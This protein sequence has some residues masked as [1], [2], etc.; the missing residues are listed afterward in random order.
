MK[1]HKEIAAELHKDQELEIAAYQYLIKRLQTLYDSI[2]ARVDK[3]GQ[4]R[5][6]HILSL[7]QYESYEEAHEAYGYDMISEEDLRQIEQYFESGQD[8]IDNTKTSVALSIL[9][10]FMRRCQRI[11]DELEF[12]LL[13]EDEKE[14]RRKA[15]EDIQKRI[16]ARRAIQNLARCIL[17]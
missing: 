16:E 6:E 8:F 11:S 9:K 1:S 3:E 5:Q 15:N 13:P 14:R 12:E 17:R 2:S 10:D 4:R 7:A